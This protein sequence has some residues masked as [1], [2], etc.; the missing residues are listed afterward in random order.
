[1]SR[2][3]RIAMI[4]AGAFGLS[5]YFVNCADSLPDTSSN[6]TKASTSLN[7]LYASVSPQQVT[8]G[9]SAQVSATGGQPPYSYSVSQGSATVS[10]VGEIS[11]TLQGS[12]V[13]SVKDANLRQAYASL[14]VNSASLPT[15]ETASNC[16]TPWGVTV[17]SGGQAFGFAAATVN[18]PATC[19]SITATCTNGAFNVALGSASCS[20]ASCT[21]KTGGGWCL[22]KGT[23]VVDVPATC[24]A[25]QYH[26]YLCDAPYGTKSGIEYRCTSP[27]EA[28]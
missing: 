13:I 22:D 18:C 24:D 5:V 19:T 2:K 14:T 15:P 27:G 9:Q 21:Y 23:V 11:A 6:T 17:V 26:Q 20:I 4:L 12:I 7:P 3:I 25:T 8:A 10:A 1:M 16:T 28:P